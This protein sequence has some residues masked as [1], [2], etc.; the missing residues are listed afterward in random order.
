LF[1]LLIA[2]AFQAELVPRSA[3]EGPVQEI[4]RAP[5]VVGSRLVLGNNGNDGTDGCRAVENAVIIH[6][7]E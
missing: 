4:A 2:R 3:N 1:G 6:W 5:A 7:H